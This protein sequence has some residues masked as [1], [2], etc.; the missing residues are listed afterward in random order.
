M[1]GET[2]RRRLHVLLRREGLVVNHKRTERIYKE[3]GLSIRTK[4]RK[5]LVNGLRL[6]L[7][8]PS[9]ANEIWAADFIHDSRSDGR[10]LNCRTLV[11]VYTRECLTI[12]V[13]SSLPGAAVVRALVH[14][15]GES[16]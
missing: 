11:D 6:A 10:R 15:Y 3:L 12:E 13:A 4:K 16:P 14:N 1:P 8:V 2:G 7:P 5:R 9:R